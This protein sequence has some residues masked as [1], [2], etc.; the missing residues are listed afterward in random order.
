MKQFTGEMSDG[1]PITIAVGQTWEAETEGVLTIVDITP[2]QVE[3]R[4]D[5]YPP[6]E[7]QFHELGGSDGFIDY[8]ETCGY[9]LKP[10][11]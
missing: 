10:T 4:F 7:T 2:T 8:L 1:S 3:L 11:T 9:T 5:F 6:G